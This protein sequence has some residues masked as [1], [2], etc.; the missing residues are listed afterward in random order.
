VPAD[1]QKAVVNWNRQAGVMRKLHRGTAALIGQDLFTAK[2]A[3]RWWL[4]RIQRATA[5]YRHPR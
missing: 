1:P 5:R 4:T 3:E 2:D